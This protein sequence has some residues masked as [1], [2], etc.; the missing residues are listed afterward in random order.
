MWFAHVGVVTHTVA[1]LL[2]RLMNSAA[3]RNAPVP[4]GACAVRTRLAKSAGCSPSNKFS[5]F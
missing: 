1:S 2:Q 4:P 3:T 5:I